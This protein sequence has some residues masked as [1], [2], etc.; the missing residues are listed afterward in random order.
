MRRMS[1]QIVLNVPPLPETGRFLL[2]VQ[3]EIEILVS[4]EKAQRAVNIFTHKKI[5]AQMRADTPTLV[6]R[7]QK[8]FWRVPVHLTIPRSGDVGE[9]GATLVDVVTGEFDGARLID[10]VHGNAGR[11]AP[12]FAHSADE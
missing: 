2:N 4:A 8:T 10:E 7:D 6:V 5:S 9:F 12:R 3:R 1:S 11:L